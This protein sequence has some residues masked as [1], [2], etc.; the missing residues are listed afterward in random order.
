MPA[1]SVHG[2][3]GGRRTAGGRLQTA[4]RMAAV[5]RRGRIRSAVD[6]ERAMPVWWGGSFA[7]GTNGNP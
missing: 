2:Q 1:A 5:Y 3:R 6:W 7:R 4:R